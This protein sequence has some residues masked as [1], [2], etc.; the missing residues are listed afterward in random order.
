MREG[1]ATKR[2]CGA[3]LMPALYAS[4]A[5]SKSLAWNCALP[6]PFFSA[7]TAT[8]W[9]KAW[10]MYSFCCTRP[11]QLTDTNNAVRASCSR[12]LPA[13][14]LGKRARHNGNHM[15]LYVASSF[16][17][18][19]ALFSDATAPG[20]YSMIRSQI[21]LLVRPMARSPKATARTHAL[22]GS[23]AAAMPVSKGG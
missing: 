12:S 23:A 21:S 10:S 2:K 13:K 1:A 6:S 4:D 15:R 5:S 22:V 3:T 16:S 11:F 9:R 19:H 8:H 7:R 18:R 20:A 17:M 14:T